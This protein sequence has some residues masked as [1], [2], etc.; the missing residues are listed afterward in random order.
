MSNA[1]RHDVSIT[2]AANFLK[3]APA[4]GGRFLFGM[5]LADILLHWVVNDQRGEING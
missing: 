5:S 1:L 4:H 2:A 3:N